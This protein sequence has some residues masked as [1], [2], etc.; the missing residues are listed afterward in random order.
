MAKLN[1]LLSELR[2]QLVVLCAEALVG[3]LLLRQRPCVVGGKPFSDDATRWS[4]LAS[5]ASS[6]TWLAQRRRR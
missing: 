5:H 1:L 3:P 2:V 6:F 4:S